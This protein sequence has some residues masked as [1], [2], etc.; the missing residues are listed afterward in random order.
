MVTF[1]QFLFAL[2]NQVIDLVPEFPRQHFE[3][4]MSVVG[5]ANGSAWL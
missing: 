2:R 1:E 4:S 3:E 5:L